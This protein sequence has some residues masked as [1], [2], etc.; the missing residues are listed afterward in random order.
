M[1]SERRQGATQAHARL[2]SS[3]SDA[4]SALRALCEY[5]AAGESDEFCRYGGGGQ[6]ALRL[7]PT[8]YG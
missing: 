7:Q 4:L 8:R 1:D 3:D 2:R 5:E 6:L